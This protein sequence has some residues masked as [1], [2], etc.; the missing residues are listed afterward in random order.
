MDSG[1]CQHWGPGHGGDKNKLQ[2]EHKETIS[3]S[4][5]EKP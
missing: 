5:S 3:L 1:I 4:A 2:V